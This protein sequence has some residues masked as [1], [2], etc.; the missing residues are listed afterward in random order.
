MHN[1]AFIGAAAE[2][3]VAAHYVKSGHEVF[4]P[5]MSQ[6]CVDMIVLIEGIPRKVQVN[7]LTENKA[8]D[9]VYL[10]V[11]LQ[12]SFNNNSTSQRTYTED[13]FDYLV[14][15]HESGIWETPWNLCYGKT[16][17]TIGKL[18]DGTVQ[19]RRGD[20]QPEDYRIK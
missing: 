20:F 1:N 15:Y 17:M 5:T 14:C 6:A 4:M 3:E 13:E 7:K 11:R 10:Q 8:G 18:V 19:R 12:G 9:S 2:L 16:S